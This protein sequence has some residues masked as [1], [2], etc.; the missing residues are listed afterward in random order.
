LLS[1]NRDFW[2]VWAVFF[3]QK[4][5]EVKFK[6]LKRRKIRG[7]EIQ[8]EIFFSGFDLGAGHKKKF[9]SNSLFVTKNNFPV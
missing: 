3:L 2:E 1:D 7:L 9:V 4:K 8:V 5:V 6:I